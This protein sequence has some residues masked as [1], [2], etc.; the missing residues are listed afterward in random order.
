ME[1]YNYE[2]FLSDSSDDYPKYGDVKENNSLNKTEDLTKESFKEVIR[3]ARSGV[4]SW[5]T[6]KYKNSAETAISNVERYI[7]KNI[8]KTS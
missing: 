2:I 8:F 1:N 6:E 4:Q 7:E 3:L 5:W